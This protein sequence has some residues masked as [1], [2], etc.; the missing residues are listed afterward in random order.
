MM[1]GSFSG[2]AGSTG[3]ASWSNYVIAEQSGGETLIIGTDNA[4]KFFGIPPPGAPG[5]RD[6]SSTNQ[7]CPS[8]VSVQIMGNESLNAAKGQLAAGVVPANMDIRG[9]P[10]TWKQIGAEFISYF[11]PRLLSGGKLALRG[12]QMNSHPLN[13]TDV[14]DF[15]PMLSTADSAV[16]YSWPADSRVAPEGWAPMFISNPDASDITLLVTVEWRVRFNIGN[17][18]VASHQ[19]HGVTSDRAWDDHIRAAVKVLPGV[20]DIVENVA[21]RGMA[22]RGAYSAMAA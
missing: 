9:S 1:V 17:P 16:G 15:R 12:V 10:L 6:G 22:L 3:E 18:A 8:A 4:T 21:Q 2:S 19:H 5:Y 13:M 11:R 20:I 7:C 14:S